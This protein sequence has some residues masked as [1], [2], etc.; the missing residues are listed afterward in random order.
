MDDGGL[1]D[2]SMDDG[3]MDDRNMDDSALDDRVLDDGGLNDDGLYDRG[4]H[5]GELN[6]SSLHVSELDDSVLHHSSS[7]IE[8]WIDKQRSSFR[9]LANPLRNSSLWSRSLLLLRQIRSR[10]KVEST[11]RL[12]R[13]RMR[14]MW[15]EVS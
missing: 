10:Y 6:D 2:S 3:G 4:L 7:T 11:N 5:D 1:D 12:S 13:C 14:C 15:R 9:A 8:F